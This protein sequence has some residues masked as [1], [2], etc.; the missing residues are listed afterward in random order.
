MHSTER[1]CA[2]GS[3]VARML[4]TVAESLVEVDPVGQF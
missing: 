2:T 4:S 3:T 1:R